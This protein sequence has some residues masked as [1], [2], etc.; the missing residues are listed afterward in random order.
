MTVDFD[1]EERTF[2]EMR[3]FLESNDR[4]QRERAWKSMVKR[5]MENSE[6][7]S[8]IFDDLISIRHKIAL[9][10]GFK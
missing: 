1:G 4:I 3:G 6:E 8:D 9:N 10:S 2:P 5:W 7:L